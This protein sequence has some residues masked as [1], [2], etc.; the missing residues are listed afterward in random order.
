MADL[1][2]VHLQRTSI[3]SPE[4]IE[5]AI[6]GSNVVINL[7]GKHFETMRWSFTDVHTTFPGVLA[8]V[9][10]LLDGHANA[11]ARDRYSFRPVLT[12]AVQS[13]R[14]EVAALLLVPHQRAPEQCARHPTQRPFHPGFQCVVSW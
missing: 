12:R 11:N 9:E 13:G 14:T 10:R 6:D 5:A 1:G 4:E 2:R 8:E 3:R 7:L